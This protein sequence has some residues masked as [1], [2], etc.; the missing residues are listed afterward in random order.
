MQSKLLIVQQYF[1]AGDI[2][3]CQSIA[4]HFIQQGYKV[5]WPVEKHFVEG[6]NRAYPDV[7]FVDR[8]LMSGFDFEN[9]K[10]REEAGVRLLP[11]RYSEYLMGR[12]YK[13]HMV[14][15]YTYLDLDWVIWRKHARPIRDMEKENRLLNALGIENGQEYNFTQTLF[16]SSLQ[17]PINIE[18]SNGLPNIELCAVEGF[19]LFDWCSVIERATNIHAVSSATLYLFEILHLAAKSIHLYVRKPVEQDFEYVNFLF[20]KPYILHQ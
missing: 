7:L 19:S 17:R 8:N 6:F 5:L 15:K 2:I 9:K 16:G 12:P 20:T 13:F 14:S 1:G 18:V 3:F 4:H 10:Y 11:L